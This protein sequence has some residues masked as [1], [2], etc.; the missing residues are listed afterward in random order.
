[1]GVAETWRGVPDGWL[2]GVTLE[3]NI[4]LLLCHAS[5]AA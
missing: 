4:P 5:G 1:M 3:S 2:R